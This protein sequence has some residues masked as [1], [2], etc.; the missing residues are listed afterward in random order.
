MHAA[1]LDPGGNG[2]NSGR[3]AQRLGVP[4]LL[5]GF[6]GGP[7]GEQL[8]AL[9]EAE[10]LKHRFI[11][12]RQPTRTNVTVTREDNGQQ[13]RLTFPGP[14]ISRAEIRALH[15]TIARLR[16]PGICLLG[17]SAPQGADSR[18]YPSVIRALQER[19]LGVGVDVPSHPLREILKTLR[20]P[21]LLLKPNQTELEQILVRPLRSDRA[22]ASAALSLNRYA[23]LVCVSLADRGAIGAFNGKTWFLESPRIKAR[24]TVGAGDSMVGAMAARLTGLGLTNPEHVGRAPTREI[25]SVLR[26]GVAA[27]AATAATVGTSLGRAA[28]IR[29]LYSKVTSWELS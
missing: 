7:A 21:L 16:G 9:L 29:R 3:I 13:T 12:I 25:L 18:F 15:S 6:A 11:A 23:S 1:R 8:K 17:G 19:G 28:L 22:I 2:I 24:G 20:R 27:G 26:W 10:G 4:P 14:K 5:L